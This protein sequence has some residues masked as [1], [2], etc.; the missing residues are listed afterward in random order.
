MKIRS[1]VRQSVIPTRNLSCRYNQ[2]KCCGQLPKGKQTKQHT[3]RMKT[4]KTAILAKYKLKTL[5]SEE[6]GTFIL[7]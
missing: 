4:T 3:C 2:A 1:N 7:C 6:V 5:F